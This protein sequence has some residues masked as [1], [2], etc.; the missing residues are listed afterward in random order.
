MLESISDQLKLLKPFYKKGCVNNIFSWK[1]L[2]NLVNLRPFMTTSRFKF[3]NNKSYNWPKVKW[4]TDMN[5]YPIEILEEELKHYM[6]HVQDCSRVNKKINQI[7][8]ELETIFNSASDAQIFFTT[9]LKDIS[10][11]GFGIHNDDNNNFIVQVEGVTNIRIW[12]YPN[13]TDA[14]Y[15]DSLNYEPIIDLEMH[16][17]D[18]VFIP[19][20]HWHCVTPK[21]KRL[22]ISFSLQYPTDID[23]NEWQSRKWIDFEDMLK[24][25]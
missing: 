21:T 18:V 7:S 5:T 19:Y 24:N 1:E 17:G 23:T 8:Y 12:D 6:G 2:E 3:V 4:I 14:I 22:S 10:V 25:G 9:N 20:K 15:T 11:Y 13:Q 16:P